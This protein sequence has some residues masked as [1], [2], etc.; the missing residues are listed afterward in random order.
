MSRS[1]LKMKRQVFAFGRIMNRVPGFADAASVLGLSEKEFD[2]DYSMVYKDQN[3]PKFRVIA[4][5]N[6]PSEK[7]A[8]KI[9]ECNLEHCV[10]SAEG[11]ESYECYVL[12]ANDHVDKVKDDRV[13]TAL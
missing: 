9:K 8:Q 2:K 1:W 4:F 13:Y 12:I 3:R 10:A 11:N 5:K 7:V 6:P